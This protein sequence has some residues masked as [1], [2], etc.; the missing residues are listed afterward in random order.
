MEEQLL[1]WSAEAVKKQD[2]QASW[3]QEVPEGGLEIGPTQPTRE[4]FPANRDAHQATGQTH[5]EPEETQALGS[6]VHS[7]YSKNKK[8]G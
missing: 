8:R 7:G 6:P 3:K 1:D 2:G 5:S 4:V